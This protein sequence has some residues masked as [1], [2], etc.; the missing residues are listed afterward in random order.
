MCCRKVVKFDC[1]SINTFGET[2]LGTKQ[3]QNIKAILIKSTKTFKCFL[4]IRYRVKSMYFHV[5]IFYVYFCI[6]SPQKK[7]YNL[8]QSLSIRLHQKSFHWKVSFQVNV[9]K[10][11]VFSLKSKSRSKYT[12]EISDRTVQWSDLNSM[13]VKYT[14]QYICK[15]CIHCTLTLQ[16]D[17]IRWE[18]FMRRSRLG[19]L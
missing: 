19:K 11:N 2:G 10:K 4:F 9:E 16:C 12:F 17:A 13:Y 7:I 5:V 1:F 6:C 3:E 14:V 8:W 15:K 18:Q